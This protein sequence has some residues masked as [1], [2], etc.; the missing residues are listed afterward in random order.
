MVNVCYVPDRRRLRIWLHGFLKTVSSR[1]SRSEL[2]Q[3]KAAAKP[4]PAPAGYVTDDTVYTIQISGGQAKI[5]NQAGDVVT[6]LVNEKSDFLLDELLHTGSVSMLVC[7]VCGGTSL[8]VGL[9]LYS[10]KKKRI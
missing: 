7:M 10:G 3:G 9:L 1:I 6:K 2:M 5:L 4:M 8:I